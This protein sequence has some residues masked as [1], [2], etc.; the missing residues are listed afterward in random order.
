MLPLV[1]YHQSYREDFRTLKISLQFTT[2]GSAKMQH[3]P[4]NLQFWTGRSR[5]PAITGSESTEG[6]ERG[7]Q[8]VHVIW[9]HWFLP[10]HLFTT[11]P[12][13]NLLLGMHSPTPLPWRRYLVC[14]S[15]VTVDTLPTAQGMDVS[16]EGNVSLEMSDIQKW[17]VL[18][19]CNSKMHLA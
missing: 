19:A 3:E 11:P 9:N 10:L 6:D 2:D 13:P 5:D 17:A 8:Y 1:N 7:F 12:S 4:R 16:R 18:I 14:R 15:E